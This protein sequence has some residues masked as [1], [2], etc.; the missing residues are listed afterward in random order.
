MSWSPGGNFF[1][2]FIY[3][4]KSS[5]SF[6]KHVKIGF[7]Q[8]QPLAPMGG[9]NCMD[10][11]SFLDFVLVCR[12]S[13]RIEVFELLCVIW[14]RV[15]QRRNQVLHG[16]Y[17]FPI[18]DIY[19]WAISLMKDFRD[20]NFIEGSSSMRMIQAVPRWIPPLQGSFKINTDAAVCV[21]DKVSGIGVVIRDSN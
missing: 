2:A 18:Y 4:R 10:S 14:W 16:K 15:W 7:Q 21:R 17:T 19:D 5:Y 20:S 8:G 11:G 9:E 3:L 1:G 13:V 6:G 12:E